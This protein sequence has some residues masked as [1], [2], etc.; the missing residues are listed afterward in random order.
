MAEQTRDPYE[1]K[2]HPLNSEIFR[3][4]ATQD[5]I[6]SVRHLGI[7][8]PI[9]ITADDV[10]ISGHR[11][12]QAARIAELETVPVIVRSDLKLAHEV[13]AAWYDANLNRE[14]TVEQRARWYSCREAFWSAELAPFR[15]AGKP[16]YLVPNL[17]QGSP[18]GDLP[19][20]L[21]EGSPKGS[22]ARDKAGAETGLARSTAAKA[23]KV[24]QA[25]DDAAEA[26]DTDRADELRE[27]LN[28]KSVSAAVKK[29]DP[30]PKPVAE[31][32]TASIVLDAL[33][34]PI[35]PSYR[36]HNQLGITLLKLGRDVDKFRQEARRLSEVPGGE[37]LRLGLIDE[38]VRSLKGYFQDSRYHTLCHRCDG[39]VS[40]CKTCHGAGFL[41]D[42]LK[43]TI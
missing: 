30:D 37:W 25:I 23:K 38:A 27:A 42:W 40:D 32:S 8:Q 31:T 33:D 36:E 12:M 15:A 19:P 9:I 10:V 34:R 35:P 28:T 39:K 3:D 13:E 20:N 11:R 1:L 14:M 17:A 43:G 24:V 6:D 4:V 2:N 26:G 18:K 29:L 16:S 7:L 22:E 21:A 41:P 5:L